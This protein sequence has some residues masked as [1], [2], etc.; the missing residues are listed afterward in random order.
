MNGQSRRTRQKTCTTDRK[1][2]VGVQSTRRCTHRPRQFF[3]KYNLRHFRALCSMSYDASSV[4]FPALSPWL[5]QGSMTGRREM[6]TWVES[7]QLCIFVQAEMVKGGV[8]NYRCPRFR[9]QICAYVFFFFQYTRTYE[10]KIKSFS[11]ADG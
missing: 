8:K 5:P 4:L 11:G 2:C 10:A 7:K 3:S 1:P 6:R 9:T